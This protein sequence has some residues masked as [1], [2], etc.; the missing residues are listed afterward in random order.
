MGKKITKSDY[1]GQV[2]N[3]DMLNACII[4]LKD[5]Q[6]FS[7]MAYKEIF[8]IIDEGVGGNVFRNKPKSL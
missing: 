1:S 8:A 2:N 3:L 4:L 6:K 7:G 5:T